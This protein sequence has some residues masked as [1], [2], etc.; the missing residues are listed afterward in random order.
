MV[1]HGCVEQRQASQSQGKT[2]RRV[3]ARTPAFRDVK[4]AIYQRQLCSTRQNS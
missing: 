4:G 3:T 2:W 1:V